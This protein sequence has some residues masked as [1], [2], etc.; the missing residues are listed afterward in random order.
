[1]IERRLRVWQVLC[2][3]PAA[4]V[5]LFV[6]PKKEIDILT[7]RWHLLLHFATTY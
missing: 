2:V 7:Q 1:M 6:D 4:E 5:V 3:S